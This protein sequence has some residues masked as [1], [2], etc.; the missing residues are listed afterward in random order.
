M[1]LDCTSR[2]DWFHAARW[3]VS[4][5]YLADLASNTQAI[6]LSPDEWNRQIDAFDVEGLADQ[7]AAAK[8]GYY[9]LT[10]GQNSG[11]YLSPN[12]AY[13]RFTGI[14]PS[15]CSRRDVIAELAAALD[16]RGIPLL[17]YLP[18]GAPTTDP[19]ACSKLQWEWGF[20]GGHPLEG[21]RTGKR[22]REFQVMWEEIIREWSLRW[23]SRVK[24]WWFDGC[25]F[26]DEMYRHPDAPNF[27]SFAAA[28]RA[29]NPDSLVSFNPGIMLTPH[30][31]AEDFTAG[32]TNEPGELDC[33]DRW[34]VAP[35]GHREQYHVWS[36][37]GKFWGALPLRYTTAQAYLH[38]RRI[39]DHGGVFTWDVPIQKDGRL[40][41]EAAGQ[42][43]ELGKALREADRQGLITPHAERFTFTQ[44]QPAVRREDGTVTP[45]VVEVRIE[46]VGDRAEL[47]VTKAADPGVGGQFAVDVVTEWTIPRLSEMPALLEIEAVLGAVPP[48]RMP[49]VELRFAAAGD[50]LLLFARVDDQAIG[51]NPAQPWAGS[52]VELFGSGAPVECAGAAAPRVSQFFLL[53]PTAKQPAQVLL[54]S[55]GPVP[56]VVPDV[57]MIGM[58][59]DAC[60]ASGGQ[61]SARRT[62]GRAVP[63]PALDGVA[64]Y[65]LSLR[66]PLRLFPGWQTESGLCRLEVV[67]TGTP[68][69]P[70][71]VQRRA[72]FNCAAPW[73]HAAGLS[74]ARLEDGTPVPPRRA[75]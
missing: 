57:E 75:A 37:L 66:L 15:K 45:A 41:A 52:C 51:V 1:K 25:Y 6:N 9:M 23:G 30:S 33:R 74:V 21:K 59:V 63:R 18:S 50:S 47:L 54:S 22:L 24:G 27:H 7:L 40:P 5:H 31:A 4:S 70:G 17:A 46:N 26:A 38:T 34:V 12:D 64:G 62:V 35:D 11:F 39:V 32:E 65:T 2:T 42:L 3:G 67:V 36:F 72:L 16:R 71:G 19:T 55:G 13:D 56:T 44:L 69:T 14:Q 29:G 58:L 61:R 28:A 53:P 10:I 49:G 8:V 68:T 60:V 48:R 20:E 43:A 73:R